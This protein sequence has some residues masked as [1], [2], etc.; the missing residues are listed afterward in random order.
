M[1]RGIKGHAD[2]ESEYDSVSWINPH[3]DYVN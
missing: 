1:G 3:Y 2:W